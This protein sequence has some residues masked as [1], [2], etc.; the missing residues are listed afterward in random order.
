M[1]VLLVDVDRR[2]PTPTKFRGVYVPLSSGLLKRI[3]PQRT[4]LYLPW[5]SPKVLTGDSGGLKG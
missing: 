4:N 1:D 5:S 2:S 3:Q